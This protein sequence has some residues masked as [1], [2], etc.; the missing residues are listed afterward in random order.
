MKVYLAGPMRGYPE[1]N[2]P[3]FRRAAV[4]LRSLGHEVFSPAEQHKADFEKG[5]AA[6]DETLAAKEHGFDRRAA[7]AKDMAYICEHADAI[8]V[9]PGWLESRGARAEHA[10]AEALDLAVIEI[11]KLSGEE[12]R[13]AHLIEFLSSP[14]PCFGG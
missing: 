12:E 14:R 8:A 13:H 10:A 9:L 2:F 6:G 4:Y 3:A 11:P 7:M 1:F 5:N